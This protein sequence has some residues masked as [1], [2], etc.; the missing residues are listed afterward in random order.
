MQTI[1]KKAKIST[2]IHTKAF[3][4]S[5]VYLLCEKTDSPATAENII[6][7]LDKEAILTLK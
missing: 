2:M 1:Y 5:Y 6:D 4:I 7:F 3:S